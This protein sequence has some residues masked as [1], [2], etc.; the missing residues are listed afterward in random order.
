MINA[1]NLMGISIV[2]LSLIGCV[3]QEVR[4]DLTPL[5]IQTIQTRTYAE[6]KEIVFR[7]AMSVFQDIGYSIAS[8]DLNTGLITGEGA[9]QDNAALLFWTGTTQITQTRATAFIE[10][11]GDSTSVRLSFVEVDERSS[12]HGQRNRRDTPILDSE[13]YQNAFDRIENAIFIRTSG[14]R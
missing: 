3:G 14:S 5:E 11:L 4:P 7:S 13:V 10:E 8:A 12:R 2:C 9:A 1:R 6:P